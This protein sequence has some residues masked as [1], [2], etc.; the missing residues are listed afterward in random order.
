MKNLKTI[1]KALII[2]IFVSA[3]TEN[4][5][6]DFLQTI[7]L[8]SNI[9][10]AYNLTQDN[11]GVVTITPTA[12]GAISFDLHLGDATTT[13]QKVVQGKSF[14]H[15]YLE[16]TYD[17]KI[18]AYNAVGKTAEIS[19]P[20]VVSFKA[21]ENLVV[22]IE[23]DA[24][25]SKQVNITATADFAATYD[26]YSGEQNVT[27]PVV[28]GNIGDVINYQYKEAGTYDVK[29]VAKG[30]AIQT[31]EYI[32][33]F[34]VTAILAPIE[35]VATPASRNDQDVISIF[36]D[37]YTDITGVDYY[38]N[39]GQQTQY[40]L[41]D[42][43]GDKMLQYSNLNY[44]GIDFSGNVQD[45]STM[46]T[47]HIDVWTADATEIKI[48]P[49]SS[50]SPEY[51]V[52]KALV[53]NQWNSFEISLTDFT[54]QGLVISD[55]KQFKF[56]GAGTIFIDNL[57]FYKAPSA[58]SVL[59]G[60]WKVAPEAGSLKVGPSKGSGEWYSI[61]AAGVAQRACFFDDE[62]IFGADSSFQNSLGASTWLEGWQ[63]ASPD[64]CGTPV[65]P[66]DGSTAA[67]FVHD[68]TTNKLTLNGL[69]AYLGLPKV[70]NAG[71]LPNI[72]V[73][74]S[75][76]YDITLSNNNTVMEVSIETGSGVFWTYK[77]IKDAAVVASPVVGTWKVA[78]EPGALRVGPAAGSGEWF[79]IDAAGVTERAC[80][81]DDTYVFDANGNFENKLG[82][83]TW[84]EGWQAGSDACNTPVAPHD[85]SNA[86]TFEFDATAGTIKLNGKG[87]YLGLPKVNN[88]NELT[89]PAA[90]PD[91][92]TYNVTLSNNNTEMEVIIEVG[93]GTFWT[94]KLVKQ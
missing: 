49:I 66:H 40:N 82:A 3:C 62:Y 31:T 8:P 23:N 21:P 77:L 42:L 46:E 13:P 54:D 32:A 72:T 44:Q 69:G 83:D 1:F 30:S 2:F 51:F 81:F 47:L 7:P 5:N 74:N 16:G 75:V 56:E 78:A 61:D 6:L 34:E 65:A 29:I 36:S 14:T 20:L 26:F 80:Y 24:A 52:T 70:Y 87:A 93:S 64:S 15:T 9:S 89:D 37:A 57:Y 43:N 28:S 59:T 91:S 25:I 86:A 53:A 60:T 33:S 11:S 18:V 90:A 85:G 68:V 84:V 79:A 67:T 58:A 10:A 38:P 92:I 48:F 71:E 17:V 12:D 4:N 22:T 88:T 63:G 73:P 55:L 19:Q 76:T 94:Y 45:A 50:S 27:Q 35:S 41:F 39:W